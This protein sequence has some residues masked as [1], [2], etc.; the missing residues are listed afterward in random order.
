MKKEEK[1]ILSLR[2]DALQQL[3]TLTELGA[4]DTQTFYYMMQCINMY[5]ERGWEETVLDGERYYEELA[6]AY[7]VVLE[8]I[9]QGGFLAYNRY[10]KINTQIE[11]KNA[12]KRELHQRANTWYIIDGVRKKWSAMTDHEKFCAD[13]GLYETELHEKK[14]EAESQLPI[15]I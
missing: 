12:R 14:E 6:S 2:K 7:K 9:R 8:S 10:A 11:E 4:M 1:T 15:A 3:L 5:E 13:E